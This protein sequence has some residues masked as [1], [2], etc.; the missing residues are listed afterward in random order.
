[1]ITDYYYNPKEFSKA[2]DFP[3]V[4]GF[5]DSKDLSVLIKSYTDAMNEMQKDIEKKSAKEVQV[6]GN[7]YKVA[8][9]N[10]QPWD[11]I[12]AWELNYYAGTVLKYLLRYKHKNG[13]EDLLKAR[14]FLDKMIEDYEN[15]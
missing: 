9:S 13:K 1:M 6:G 15:S 5:A 2:W 7:H 12:D 11:I 3:K 4:S 10:M 8:G 14:H